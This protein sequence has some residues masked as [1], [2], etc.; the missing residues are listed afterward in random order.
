ML[1]ADLTLTGIETA[2]FVAV[3]LALAGARTQ[4]YKFATTEPTKLRCSNCETDYTV[5][6]VEAPPTHN[7]PLLCLSCGA[8]LRNRDGKFALKYFRTDGSRRP[9]Y[10]GSKLV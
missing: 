2:V 4:R 5:V 3:V 9:M 8:A 10:R 7:D 6:R 1:P